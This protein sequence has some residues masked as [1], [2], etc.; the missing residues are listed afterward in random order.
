MLNNQHNSP[1]EPGYIEHISFIPSGPM[2]SFTYSLWTCPKRAFLKLSVIGV[3]T[4]PGLTVRTCTPILD[5]LFLRPAQ[6]IE[7][8]PLAVP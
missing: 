4:N 5:S 2:D 6:N 3:S 8:A 1:P 7:S